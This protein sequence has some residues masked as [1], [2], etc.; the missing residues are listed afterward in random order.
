MEYDVGTFWRH[1]KRSS[2]LLAVAFILLDI[3]LVKGFNLNIY[4]ISILIILQGI[5]INWLLNCGYYWA[6]TDNEWNKHR[7]YLNLIIA[8]SLV[9]DVVTYYLYTIGNI[10]WTILYVCII[11]TCNISGM[12]FT[13]NKV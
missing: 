1:C 12:R 13:L 8:I 3:S 6:H 5:I 2:I 4:Y 9:L 7:K 10:N 11:V